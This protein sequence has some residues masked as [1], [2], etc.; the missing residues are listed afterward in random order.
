MLKTLR[1]RKALSQRDL[2]KL[3]GISPTTVNRIEQKLVTPN[4]A[5]KKKIAM[6]LEVRPEDIKF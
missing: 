6:A 5:T 1:D 4:P 2:A 3:A